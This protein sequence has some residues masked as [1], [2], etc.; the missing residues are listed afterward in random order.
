MEKDLKPN[1][2]VNS[3]AQNTID[4][5]NTESSGN[6]FEDF[7]AAKEASKNMAQTFVGNADVVGS[8]DR[9]GNEPQ[10]FGQFAKSQSQQVPPELQGAFSDLQEFET[11]KQ[12]QQAPNTGGTLATQNITLGDAP[13]S[14]DIAAQSDFKNI[15]Y[16][17]KFEGSAWDDF[18]NSTV[19]AGIIQDRD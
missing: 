4:K 17:D 5:T 14:F 15:P 16:Y 19:N 8:Q 3:R 11:Q 1:E 6:S 9:G 13:A 12:A 10:D 7:V 18:Y 2:A